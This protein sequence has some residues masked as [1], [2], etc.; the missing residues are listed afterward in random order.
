MNL[1]MWI[2]YPSQRTC[3]PGE[4][5]QAASPGADPVPSFPRVG[6]GTASRESLLRC[7]VAVPAPVLQL[8]PGLTEPQTNRSVGHRRFWF[9]LSLV[10]NWLNMIPLIVAD[11]SFFGFSMLLRNFR[12]NVE[13]HH[14]SIFASVWN[15]VWPTRSL[16]ALLMPEQLGFA[17]CHAAWSELYIRAYRHVWSMMLSENI[18]FLL[19]QRILFAHLLAFPRCLVAHAPSVEACTTL[20]YEV[21]KSHGNCSGV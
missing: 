21:L 19:V 6:S 16:E 14:K 1:L 10:W 17:S 13:R 3:Q 18:G 11:W 7:R 9:D 2:V 12:L 5:E 20:S 8:R 15:S 4:A